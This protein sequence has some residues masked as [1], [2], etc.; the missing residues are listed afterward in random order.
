MRPCSSV[1]WRP[2][3]ARTWRKDTP[4]EPSGCCRPCAL[5]LDS[6]RLCS[7]SGDAKSILPKSFSQQGS[8]CPK[9]GTSTPVCD[10]GLEAG[11]ASCWARPGAC[12]SDSA[13]Q[14]ALRGTWLPACQPAEKRLCVEPGRLCPRG[15]RGPWAH[16]PPRQSSEGRCLAGPAWGQSEACSPRGAGSWAPWAGREPRA[17]L[18]ARFT[19]VL[20]RRGGWAV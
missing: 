11:R 13:V 19:L 10:L 14:E 4:K 5:R 16:G 1:V 20:H 12:D 9:E 6:G 18:K 15:A 7:G 2:L 8:L 3:K 17:G